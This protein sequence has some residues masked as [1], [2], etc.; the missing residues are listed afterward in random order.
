MPELKLAKLP[1]RKP[2]KITIT[3]SPRLNK[4][5]NAYA[6]AYRDTYGETEHVRAL[7]PFMLE[8]FLSGDRGFARAR[9]I[10]TDIPAGAGRTRAK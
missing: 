7:I 3:V 6:L 5:L 9:R 10:G 8:I 2:V 4:A 1:D